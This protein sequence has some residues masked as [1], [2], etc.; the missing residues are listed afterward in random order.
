MNGQS[1]H[2]DAKKRLVEVK[3]VLK[4]SKT[5]KQQLKGVC[6]CYDQFISVQSE[7]EDQKSMSL[8]KNFF[9]QIVNKSQGEILKYK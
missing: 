1:R 2:D 5:L 4:N 8:M 9:L 3:D 6:S 7:K